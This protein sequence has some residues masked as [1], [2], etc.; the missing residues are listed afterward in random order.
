VKAHRME[1]PGAR[2]SLHQ[3]IGEAMIRAARIQEESR[4][5]VAQARAVTAALERTIDESRRR[6]AR[7]AFGN[8][9]LDAQDP[10]RAG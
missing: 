10:D 5:A 6:R 2:A 1:R 9:Q 4:E 3:L 7:R 8:G